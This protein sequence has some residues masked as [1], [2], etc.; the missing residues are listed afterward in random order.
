M[1]GEWSDRG[2]ALDERIV[3]RRR[4]PHLRA[5][6]MVFERWLQVLLVALLSAPLAAAHDVE[7]GE[8]IDEYR[9]KASYLFSLSKFITWPN[10]HAWRSDAPLYI[11][12]YG[13]NPFSSHLETLGPLVSRSHPIAIRA[14]EPSGSPLGCGIL[15]IGADNALPPEL[16]SGE[17]AAAGILTVGESEEFLRRGGLVSLVREDN[18]VRIALNYNNAKRAGF[19]ID[20]GLLDVAKKFE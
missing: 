13:Y 20:G 10:E 11:C 19:V 5:G 18:A 3:P 8:P 15:F 9:V 14:I 6:R 7:R 2:A 16:E 4:D 17:F 12:I 1:N